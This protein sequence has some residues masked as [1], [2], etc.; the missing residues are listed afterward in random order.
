MNKMHIIGN[1]TRDPEVKQSN[2]GLTICNFS[3]AVN[4]HFKN[5]QTGQ[6]ETDFFS[7]VAFRQLG[8]LCS[9]YLGKGRKV[10]V[11]GSMQSRSYEKDGVKRTVWELVADEVE[12]LTASGEKSDAPEADKKHPDSAE[13]AKQMQ[14]VKEMFAPT[15]EDL[16]F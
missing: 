11:V 9:K 4:R 12:F 5:P 1:V 15:D 16:P 6:T 13:M 8:E 7:V 14:K 3:V 2:A 10:A